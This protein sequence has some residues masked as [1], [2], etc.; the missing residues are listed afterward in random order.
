MVAQSLLRGIK[1]GVYV[2]VG[3]ADPILYS[4]TYHFYKKGWQGLAIDPNPSMAG[5]YT[6]L[7]P[8]DTFINVGVGLSKDSL[9][10]HAFNDETY[11]TFDKSEASR[12]L[13]ERKNVRL[14]SKKLV[15]IRPLTEIL[16]EQMVSKVDFLNVDVQGLDLEVLKSHDWSIVPTVIAVEDEQFNADKPQES[17]VYQFLADK[18]YALKGL[19]Q[20]TLI[21]KKM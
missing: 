19:C 1:N 4:V 12:Y 18:G 11:N 15:S 21:F 5:R 10:Y 2:D 14:I 6:V 7:R 9:E 16:K 20:L 3:C 8:R 17:A 13:R